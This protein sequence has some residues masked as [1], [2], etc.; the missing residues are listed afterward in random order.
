MN[1]V[2]PSYEI[3]ELP[4]V[5]PNFDPTLKTI[6]EKFNGFKNWVIAQ[7]EAL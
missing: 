4:K 7:I 3:P 2:I 5:S 1:I 6:E